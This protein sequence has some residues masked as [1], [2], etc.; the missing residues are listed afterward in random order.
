MIATTAGILWATS[1]LLRDPSL[2]SILGA[3]SYGMMPVAIGAIVGVVIVMVRTP[4]AT[5]F[6]EIVPANLTLLLNLKASNA[7]VA[8]LGSA[9]G[10]FSLWS[11]ALTII[12]LAK[13]L[14]RSTGQAAAI[15]LVPWGAW[16]V[17]KT[18][19]AAVMG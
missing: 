5:S 9:I 8:S 15:V 6:E 13:G 12:G 18:A 3:V 2:G 10:V 7:I 14:G 4:D 19:F 16:V 17:L 1:R 11:I